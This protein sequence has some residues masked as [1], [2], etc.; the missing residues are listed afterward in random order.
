MKAIIQ[1][2]FTSGLGDF[3][4]S[5]AE[6]IT[7]AHEL[8]KHN[9]TIELILNYSNNKYIKDINLLFNVIDKNNSFKIFNTVTTNN[10]PIHDI[11]INN[12]KHYYTLS[13]VKP[14]SHWWD[15][16][17]DDDAK[18]LIEKY[19]LLNIF[20]QN[21]YSFNINNTVKIILPLFTSSFISK[22]NNITKTLFNNDK[23][24]CMF[25]RNKDLDNQ[26]YKY[27]K[28]QIEIK[29]LFL[30]NQHIY[31]SSNSKKFKQYIKSQYNNVIT[32]DI[33]SYKD[34]E[35]HYPPKQSS[36]DDIIL[37]QILY[38]AFIDM[39]IISNAQRIYLF[40]DWDRISNFLFLSF[41]KKIPIYHYD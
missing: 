38:Q 1:S 22:I 41:Y 11:N 15:L 26:N 19:N 13:Y 10:F 32:Y 8:K 30:N 27:L 2:N 36:N 28:N 7:L 33:K 24:I 20:S 18:L 29:N 17:L 34:I 31:I 21:D 12:C 6:Y 35:Y 4:V 40:S 16:F 9:C 23:Y 5:L 3:F 39:I 25:F 37:E 14:G